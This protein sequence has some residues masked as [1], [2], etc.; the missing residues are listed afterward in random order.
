MFV[1][2]PDFQLEGHPK[3]FMGRKSIFTHRILTFT[4]ETMINSVQ[5][6]LVTRFSTYVLNL[7]SYLYF[8]VTFTAQ[9]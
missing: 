3:P 9:I 8:F 4:C 1:I 5:M 2:V 7:L 6:S